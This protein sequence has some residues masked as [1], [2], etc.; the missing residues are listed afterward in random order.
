M[1]DSASDEEALAATA[2]VLSDE[3]LEAKSYVADIVDERQCKA[4]VEACVAEYGRID[5]LIN[6][7][8]IANA[9]S[10]VESVTDADV[11]AWAGKTLPTLQEHL[12]MAKDT[13]SKLGK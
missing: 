12:S 13:E 2:R 8:G 7:V 11:K 1:T 9:D 10:D 6:N 3:G 4:F 5:V